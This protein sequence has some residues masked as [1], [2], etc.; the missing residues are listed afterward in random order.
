MYLA[1][2][3]IRQRL[4]DIDF[5]GRL[6]DF[7]F[8][9]EKQIGAA[10]VDIR[11]D[12]KFWVTKTPSRTWWRS[13]RSPKKYRERDIVDLRH[14]DIHEAQPFLHWQQR[15]LAVGET[16][17]LQPGESVMGRTYETFSM[18]EGLAGKFAARVSYSRL[19]LLIHCGNDFINPGWR[20]QHPLQ[21]VNLSGLPI[22]IAPLFPVA[23]LSFVQLSQPSRKIYGPGDRYWHDDGGPSKWWRD[24]LVRELVARHGQDNLPRAVSDQLN[25]AIRAESFTDDQLSRLIDFRDSLNPSRFTTA[26][27]LLD[28]FARVEKRTARRRAFIRGL[29]LAAAALLWGTVAASAFVLPYGW[30]HLVVLAL[31]LAVT[32]VAIALWPGSD[33]R[34]FLPPDAAEVRRALRGRPGGADGESGRPGLS[35]S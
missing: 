10:S 30:L 20:G 8:D 35:P 3:D 14:H 13:S 31:A 9:P 2:I 26:E 21:L 17:V 16:I 12:T 7:P 24:E 11:V 4:G 33:W 32:P 19:G 6:A 18:P 15:D 28:A 5:E 29:V 25:E 23:Q 34:P 1:D 27:D 22:R